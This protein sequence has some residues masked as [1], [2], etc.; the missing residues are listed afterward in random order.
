V[1]DDKRLRTVRVPEQVEPLFLRAQDYVSRYFSDRV[2]DP[3][4]GT[5]SISGE[6]Y[7]LLRAAAMSVDFF[8]LVMSLYQDKGED[9]A[10]SVAKNLLFDIAHA[11]G[12]ADARAYEEKMGVTEPIEKLS[13]GPVHFSFSGW[14]FVDILPDSRP[15]PDETYFL[16]YDH[17]YSFESDSWVR[18]GRSSPV[19]VCIMNS[20]YSSGWCEQSFG[21]PLVAAEVECVAAGGARCRFIMAPPSRIEAHLEEHARRSQG[22]DARPVVSGAAPVAVPEFFQR[23]RMEEALRSSHE[24]L[25]RR[26]QERTAELLAANEQL[27]R[28]VAERRR[29]EEARDH[30]LSVAAHELKTPLT[31]LRGFSQLL[32]RLTDTRG[33]ADG[34]RLRQALATIEQQSVK[35]S[36][37]VAQLLDVSRLESGRLVLEPQP[38]DIVALCTASVESARASTQ[39]H[40][41]EVHAEG[42]I[43]V[44]ADPL[45]LE[46][47]LTNLLDNAIKFSPGGRV[48][49]RLVRSGPAVEIAVSDEGPGIAPEHR[50]RIFERFYQAHPDRLGGMGLG[51]HISREIV[52]LHGGSM[53]VEQPDHAGTRVVVR[54]PGPEVD[55]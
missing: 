15:A 33:P 3:E 30:F 34:R 49:V 38:T 9:E 23:K 32:L 11:I 6:R 17:P 26:V 44:S 48:D 12:R 35:L 53:R 41:I 29:A 27:R 43:T 19:P 25:E 4:H 14:A 1:T 40:S 51:L 10:R 2:D 5:I 8:D 36:R 39:R 16:I 20:G 54:L 7:I 42:P 37:L 47:V 52:D 31:S 45:R 22:T 46:Q 21:L 18:R 24:M 55:Q 13:A 28:E 50:E